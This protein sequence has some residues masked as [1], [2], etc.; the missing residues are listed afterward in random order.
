MRVA[1]EVETTRLLDDNVPTRRD[2]LQMTSTE[3][4]EEEIKEE[5]EEEEEKKEDEETKGAGG[6][7]EPSEAAGGLKR[8]LAYELVTMLRPSPSDVSSNGD[9]TLTYEY[10]D[11]PILESSRPSCCTPG[12]P[13]VLA[14]STPSDRIDRLDRLSDCC[15][16]KG[17]LH[18][19]VYE[20]CRLLPPRSSTVGAE[21]VDDTYDGVRVRCDF[22]G[23]AQ[24][25]PSHL[26]HSD[27][28]NPVW[29]HADHGLRDGRSGHFAWAVHE[30]TATTRDDRLSAATATGA[31]VSGSDCQLDIDVVC[32]ERV[33]GSTSVP[34]GD[35]LLS[36]RADGNEDNEDSNDG[37]DALERDAVDRAETTYL[38][39]HWLPLA[40]SSAG[41]LQVALEFVPT[42]QQQQQQQNVVRSIDGTETNMSFSARDNGDDAKE[43]LV[44]AEDVEMDRV[45]RS[46][47]HLARDRTDGRHDRVALNGDDAELSRSKV[48][49]SRSGGVTMYVPTSNETKA[50]ALESIDRLACSGKSSTSTFASSSCGKVEHTLDKQ[51]QD[52]YDFGIASDPPKAATRAQDSERVTRTASMASMYSG[53]ASTC[54]SDAFAY[55]ELIRDMESA[56]NPM[57][58]TA[59]ST[60]QTRSSHAEDGTRNR[61]QVEEVESMSGSTPT[62]KLKNRRRNRSFRALSRPFDRLHSLWPETRAQR[63]G[64][65]KIKLRLGSSSAGPMTL[66]L[67][68]RS[69]SS[70]PR[71]GAVELDPPDQPVQVPFQ[72]ASCHEDVRHTTSR[73]TRDRRAA[74]DGPGRLS[75]PITSFSFQHRRE[76]LARQHSSRP[77]RPQIEGE[78]GL[79]PFL[80][81]SVDPPLLR[82]GRSD[83]TYAVSDLY[84]PKSE[85]TD[86]SVART[87]TRTTAT[88]A[89][90]PVPSPALRRATS[91]PGARR[92]SGS[93]VA[94]IDGAPSCIGKLITVGNV[95]GVVRFIGTTHFATGT[96]VGIELCE[97]KGKNSG[98]IDGQK[99]FSCAPNHGIFIRASR[100]GLSLKL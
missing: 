79:Q 15:L 58:D 36:S 42:S 94:Y 21:A 60:S 67:R 48:V 41:L 10:D 12:H 71:K 29:R 14:L 30:L 76:I 74:G 24:M 37:A 32:G 3:H 47:V 33:V 98:T 50:H 86:V 17:E 82:R 39:P 44:E 73:T 64:V 40:G 23:A 95:P 20:A 54:A 72:R 100:L 65:R 52:L 97:Q 31:A 91:G 28:Q 1:G 83:S 11:L 99:Y 93:N 13:I 34:L 55:N 57:E 56:M 63:S 46:S 16:M 22:L 69:P 81:E 78:L 77:H 61:A 26:N 4:V 9:G 18:V 35:L 62:L 85:P 43:S 68:D 49:V 5:E 25:S 96:W 2:R 88:S 6:G 19:W 84:S 80:L 45:G 53:K 8:L 92:H 87:S 38:S 89:A 70:V 7:V 59:P 90:H 75:L 27:M 66:L 51:L